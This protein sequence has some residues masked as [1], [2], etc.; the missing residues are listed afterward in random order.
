MGLFVPEDPDYD[1]SRRMTGFNRYKQ[2]LSYHATDWIKLN[3]VT[4]AGF[5][6]LS[7]GIVFSV[8]SSSVILLVP[9]SL[10]GGMIFGPFLAGMYDAILRGMRD[11]FGK[12]TAHYKKSW[13]QNL[14]CSLLPGALFGLFLGFFAFMG[15]LFWISA[16]PV[17]PGTLILY[18]F[19]LFLFLLIQTLLWP[20]LVLFEL[21]LPGR[22]RN[23]ILFSAK[24]LWKVLAATFL[25]LC[26]Y[27]LLF[28]FAP[29][30]LLVV[31]FLGF[32]YIILASQ[33][34][35]YNSLNYEFHIEAQ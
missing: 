9:S 15:Y 18:L 3:L 13:S 19:S 12:W 26:W 30:T 16:V 21:P 27:G 31:P 8:L 29:W 1:E 4:T 7:L 22:F 28:L 20:Q 35:L 32:W 23:I 24:Y 10:I 11:D 14:R 25:Q 6:P 17:T 34:I 5:L 33:I 2:L